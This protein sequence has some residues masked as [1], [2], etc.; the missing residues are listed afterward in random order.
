MKQV[1][2]EIFLN[3]YFFNSV[4][5]FQP[6]LKRLITVLLSFGSVMLFKALFL[7]IRPIIVVG[8]CQ[9]ISVTF[10]SGGQDGPIIV[11]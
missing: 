1:G 7:F 8:L 5:L 9:V 3:I 6:L 4:F 11:F 10:L 2:E